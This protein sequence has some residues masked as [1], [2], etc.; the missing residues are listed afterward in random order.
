MPPALA[1]ARE[2]AALVGMPELLRALGFDVNARTRR[3]P[4]VLHG[5]ENPSAFSWRE[6]GLWRCHSCGA[7]GD[8]IA[9]VRAVRECGFREAVRFLA[10]LAGVEYRGRRVSREEV[11]QI[12][13][14]RERA[15]VAAWAVR[16]A[17]VLLVGRHARALC[18]VERLQR[19]VGERLE[20]QGEGE[21]SEALW[22]ILRRLAPVATYSLAVFYFLGN[23]DPETR[24]RFVLGTGAGRGAFLFGDCHAE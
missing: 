15:R 17:V 2:V 16:D 5:G 13:A 21:Q 18:L 9:L 3:C 10:G 6:D 11:A 4:C 8:R 23:A 7:G 20:I 24:I 22:E 14:Q 19:T 1:D 12:Y